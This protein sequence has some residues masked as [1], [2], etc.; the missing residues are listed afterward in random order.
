M[1]VCS[2]YRGELFKVF[3]PKIPWAGQY[4]RY[5]TRAMYAHYGFYSC[6]YNECLL[7]LSWLP[8][9]IA[10]RSAGR[11]GLSSFETVD[12][13]KQNRSMR[14]L[15]SDFYGSFYRRVKKQE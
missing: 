1:R 9:D 12:I 5:A 13:P 3:E 15:C 8:R 11:A 14:R 4:L 7:S 6:Y 10:D 2:K